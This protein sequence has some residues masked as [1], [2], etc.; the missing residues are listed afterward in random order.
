MSSLRFIW[1]SATC[2]EFWIE[3][4]FSVEDFKALGLAPE[5]PDP[6]SGEPASASSSS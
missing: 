4:G 3:L 2:R 1:L 6:R 5:A